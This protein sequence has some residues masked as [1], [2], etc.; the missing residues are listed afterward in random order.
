MTKQSGFRV[1]GSVLD[2]NDSFVDLDVDGV[3]GDGIVYLL[4][5]KSGETYEVNHEELREWKENLKAVGSGNIPLESDD[6]WKTLGTI[7]DQRKS[8]DANVWFDDRLAKAQEEMFAGI[9][10][11][12]R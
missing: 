3:D 1:L 7:G 9:L 12:G 5:P 11:A 6:V 8:H 4:D 10:E 2:L